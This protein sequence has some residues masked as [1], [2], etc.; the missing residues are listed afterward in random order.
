MEEPGS[1]AVKPSRSVDPGY[2]EGDQ[3]PT[4]DKQPFDFG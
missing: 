2:W 3:F 4:W 1:Q